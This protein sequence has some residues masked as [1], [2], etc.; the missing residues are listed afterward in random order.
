[1]APTNEWT[2]DAPAGA[3]PLSARATFLKQTYGHLLGAI[4]AFV[5]VELVIFKLGWAEPITRAFIGGKSW[6]LVLGAFVL[7]SWLATRFAATSASRGTQYMA[8]FGYVLAEGLIFVPILYIAD[9]YAPGAI[10]SAGLITVLGFAGLT[11]VVMLGK[12]DFSFLGT[13]LRWGGV[14]ALLL[15]V[16]AVVFGLN[17]GTWFSVA[18]VA[19]AGAAILYDTSNI[20]YR[21][22]SDR[23][24]S[25]SLSLFASVAM[26]FFYVLRIVM[27]R[28]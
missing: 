21:Y 2:V 9:T 20:L 24:V 4:M 28:R 11:A 18:M 3:M 1:M 17:L 14:V 13:L 6:L 8:L 19:L 26:M 7:V 25:A 15:I 12:G 27:D 22:P 16:G 23:Y 5:I 10:A